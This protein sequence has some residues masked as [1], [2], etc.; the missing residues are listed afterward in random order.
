MAEA[1]MSTLQ[2]EARPL[3]FPQPLRPTAASRRGAGRERPRLALVSVFDELCG[4]AAYSQFL[5][6]QLGDVFDVTVFELDQYLLRATHRSLR[7]FADRHIRQICRA[8]ASYDAV[9]LQLEHGTLGRLAVDIHRRFSWIVASAP[10]IS[11]TFH[12][13]PRAPEFDVAAWLRALARLQLP[14]ALRLKSEYLRQHLLAVGLARCLR[15]A[16]RCKH[17]AV[18]VHT[19]R[20]MREMKYIH[21][22]RQVYD[23][24]LSFLTP[25][26][27]QAI[28]SAATRSR[29]PLL[30]A[31]P[32]ESRLLGVF[33]FLGRYKGFDT[34]VR[35]MQHLPPDYHLLVFGGVHP[36]EI[37]RH[38]AIDPYLASLL[39]TAYVDTN[40]FDR[41]RTGP[42]ES[43]PGLSVAID[44]PL[45]HMLVTHPKDLS[46]RV[47]FMGALDHDDFL[48]GMAICDAVVM[49]YLEVG[50]SASGPISQSLEL[51]CRTI[52]SRTQTFLQLSRYHEGAIEFFDIGNHLEL[53][54]RIM[55]RPQFATTNRRL[56]FNTE[57]NKATYMAAN[58]VRRRAFT[59]QAQTI[60]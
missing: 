11:V 7:R 18:I 42:G 24:P 14:T 22:I 27:A 46:G 4:I 37:R 57:T 59:G 6:K 9:N 25:Q 28:R 30:D 26:D 15:R 19:R 23:H 40:L 21:K 58:P 3:T 31:V 55:A 33:G 8:I 20:D 32:A 16:Q 52:A 56:A 54:E 36:R 48:A 29:F 13:V 10:Q 12:T 47:H 49:P 45:Q 60:A 34:A 41:L 44:A 2:F 38:Q 5:K 17:V 39:D 51:G 50:Q 53:A 35:A 1:T 43:A